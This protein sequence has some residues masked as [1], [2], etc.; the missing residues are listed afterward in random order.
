[1]STLWIS[2]Y[3]GQLGSVPIANEPSFDQTPIAIS[4]TAA[5]SPTFQ[6]TTNFV[7]LVSDV[8]CS[9]LFYVKPI[10]GSAPAATA[11]NKPLFAKQPEYFGTSK[12]G[13][14]LSVISQS[15]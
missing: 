10:S 9:V 6:S 14:A 2:E 3:S 13:M 5:P 15:A 4:G 11:N 8:D 12:Q 1:M 7:R